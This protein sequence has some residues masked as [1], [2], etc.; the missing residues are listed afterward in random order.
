MDIKKILASLA[1]VFMG[2]VSLT[3]CEQVLNKANNENGSQILDGTNNMLD[4]AE[5][6][7]S[8]NNERITEELNDLGMAP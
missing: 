2:I 3:G 1:I 6:N 4:K 8:N 5:E 7:N